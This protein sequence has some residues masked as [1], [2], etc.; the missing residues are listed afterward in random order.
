[1]SISVCQMLSATLNLFWCSITT[2]YYVQIGGKIPR[3]LRQFCKLLAVDSSLTQ[4]YR[5]RVRRLWLLLPTVRGISA[6][7]HTVWH[8]ESNYWYY[9]GT[10]PYF[11]WKWQKNQNQKKCWSA[12]EQTRPCQLT[13]DIIG[14]NYTA[15]PPHSSLFWVRGV[16]GRYFRC[17]GDK[18]RCSACHV[19]VFSTLCYFHLPSISALSTV[20]LMDGYKNWEPQDPRNP[21]THKLHNFPLQPCLHWDFHSCALYPGIHYFKIYWYL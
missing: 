2:H 20:R 18:G 19:A 9:F 7:R 6:L 3:F 14:T 10:T 15:E 13:A 5:A 11:L 8:F 12:R 4:N 21:P 17:A 16:G 1:M